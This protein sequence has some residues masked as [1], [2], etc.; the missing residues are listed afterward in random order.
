MLYIIVGP[1]GSGKTN[2]AIELSS[3]FNNAP[4]INCDA[5]QI[6][7]DMD[8]GTAKCEVGS[9]IYLRHRLI[10]IKLPNESYSVMEYQ[11][12][13][14]KMV[15]ELSKDYK[16][17]I[18][19]GGTGLYLRAA[20]YDYKFL[21]EETP[22]VSDLD[23]LSNQELY[24]MLLKIDPKAAEKIH[25]NNRKRVLRAI[26]ISRSNNQTKSEIEA[27]QSHTYYYPK[28]DIKIYFINPDRETLYENINKRVDIMIQKG[29]V[30]EVKSLL[31]KYELSST[32][33]AAIGYKEIIDYLSNNSTLKDSIELIKKR[34]RNYAKRQ[35][36]FFKHQ[37]ET[38]EVKSYED[39]LKDIKK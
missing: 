18:V 11:K 29:L 10:D 20:I 32:A 34:S 4:I 30:D 2:A 28:E 13:F 27:E 14:R 33:Q 38:I 12:D 26:A 8:I 7:K 22:D 19:C 36:T 21:E 39:I 1:T 23:N 3:Y 37:F 24:D 17:I 16:D 9:D 31:D 35:V 6:Y 25:P 5:Y 15:D